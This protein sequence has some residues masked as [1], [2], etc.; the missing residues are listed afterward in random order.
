MG[1]KKVAVGT[2]T[3]LI[4]GASG[5]IVADNRANPFEDRGTTLELSLPSSVEKAGNIKTV[6]DK[7]SPRIELQKWD[8]E[9]KL[10]IRYTGIPATTTGS[11]AL[12]TNRMEWKHGAQ[13]VHAYPLATSTEM[14]DG[15]FEVEVV[16][17]EKPT[18]NIFEFAID[19]AENLDFFFQP[20]LTDEEITDGAVR[21]ENIV[22]SYAVYHK[23]KINHK[24]GQTNYA[25]GKAFHIY[26]PKAIDANNDEIWAELSYHS[27]VLSVAVPQ[28]F[29]DSATYP[30]RV[31]PTFGYTTIGSSQQKLAEQFG[32]DQTRVGN[33]VNLT[34][35]GTLDS[36]TAALN[37]AAESDLIDTIVF[38]NREDAGAN[39]HALVASVENLDVSHTSTAA[40]FTFTASDETLVADDYVLNITGNGQ[41]VGD[42]FNRQEINWDTSGGRNFYSEL[43]SGTYASAKEDPWTETE[44][45]DGSD[46]FYSLYATYS[47]AGAAGVINRQDIIWFYED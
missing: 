22:G 25:T 6:L 45:S 2:A 3:T 41:D 23:L 1:W 31:D 33:T 34:E 44:T 36:I 29:L 38:V 27:G 37:T 8:G 42:A 24:R 43:F 13:E 47:V 11:R 14:E 16:L 17:N 40:W 20:P 12:L 32:D 15:G 46:R 30:V 28:S 39:S 4:L 10:G 35:E 26:R 21:P 18:T 9:A 7:E 19:G 5:T